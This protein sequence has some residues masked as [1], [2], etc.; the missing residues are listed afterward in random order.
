M[1]K[2]RVQPPDSKEQLQSRKNGTKKR[3]N[4]SNTADF[5]FIAFRARRLFAD[6]EQLFTGGLQCANR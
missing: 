6:E 3:I 4:G 1:S 2:K 5:L